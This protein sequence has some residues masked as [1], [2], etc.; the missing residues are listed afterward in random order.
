MRK[1]SAIK[2]SFFSLIALAMFL[3]YRNVIECLEHSYLQ[4]LLQCINKYELTI[5]TSIKCPRISILILM[6]YR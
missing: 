6:R 5:L 4:V 2:I 3:H 1:A